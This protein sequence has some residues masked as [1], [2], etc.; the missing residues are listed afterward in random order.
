MF[1]DGTSLTAALNAD[2]CPH[3]LDISAYQDPQERAL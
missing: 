2:D 3:Y 1:D